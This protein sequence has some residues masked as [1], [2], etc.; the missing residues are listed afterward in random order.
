[1]RLMIGLL[2]GLLLLSGWRNLPRLDQGSNAAVA[3]CFA[4]VL[5][6][7]FVGGRKS[8]KAEAIATAVASAR[9]NAEAAA[10]ATANAQQA[11][12]VNINDG[13]RA[14]AAEMYKDV[15]WI[16]REEQ[17]RIDQVSQIE[18]VFEQYA[19]ERELEVEHQE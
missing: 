4:L 11:V 18:D 17:Q 1:M 14:R 13:A 19:A 5:I 10:Q 15:P 12:I 8:V 6:L 2:C 7:V 16:N 3:V 9:A